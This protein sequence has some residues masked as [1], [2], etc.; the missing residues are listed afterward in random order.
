MKILRYHLGDMKAFGMG[1]GLLI[2]V[3]ALAVLGL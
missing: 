3:G 1:F 2:L